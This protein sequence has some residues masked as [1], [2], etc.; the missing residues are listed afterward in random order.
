MLVECFEAVL[1]LFLGLGRFGVVFW[2]WIFGF[3]RVESVPGRGSY[4]RVCVCL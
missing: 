1:W 3:G 4:K 2:P